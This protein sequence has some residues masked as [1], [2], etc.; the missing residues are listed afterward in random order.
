MQASCALRPAFC[1]AVLSAMLAG[2]VMAE[3][4]ID[5]NQQIRPILSS[6]CFHCHGPDEADRQADLRLD[7]RDVAVTDMEVIVPGEPDDST[8]IDRI[9]SEDEEERMPPPDS[10]KSLTAEQIELLTKW[11]A[12]GAEYKKH[13]AYVPPQTVSTPTIDQAD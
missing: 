9:T 2:L 13:W 7:D 11:I 10:G 3:D 4:K 12:E 6:N 5:F 8:L 1:G